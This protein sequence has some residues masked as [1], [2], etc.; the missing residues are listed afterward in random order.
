MGEFVSDVLLVPENCQF[1][2][3]ER[4]EVC[5]KHQRWHTVVKEVRTL[6]E[7]SC[8]SSEDSMVFSYVALAGL[9][10]DR[11]RPT[12]NSSQSSCV[13]SLSLEFRGVCTATPRYFC[14][15]LKYLG[16][17]WRA[18][19]QWFQVLSALPEDLCSVPSIR[20]N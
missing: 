20:I 14:V 2:H 7:G 16:G 9:V 5:E 13:A 4:M 6:R 19:A 18:K 1:F 15:K 10:L 17:G 8:Q 11:L 3:Q 12:R